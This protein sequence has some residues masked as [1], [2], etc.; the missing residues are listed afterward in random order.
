MFKNAEMS[1]FEIAFDFIEKL[2]DYNTYDKE[3]TREVYERVLD[4]ENTFAFFLV[5]DGEYKGFCH[6]VYFDTFWMTGK[7]CY[8]S[9]IITREGER[10]KGYGT[11]MMDKAK[12]M[13]KAVGCKAL[14]LDSGM[15]RTTAHK[16]YE[17]Y[18]FDKGCYGFDLMI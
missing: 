16:F 10:C 9:S 13:A 6:G 18:G 14:V 8:V 11:L 7:T 3:A 5:E 2:W 15:P 4:D 12:E 1:D 17:D